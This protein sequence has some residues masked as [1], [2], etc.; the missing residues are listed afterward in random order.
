MKAAIAGATGFIGQLLIPFLSKDK[1]FESVDQC[2]AENLKR[3]IDE[4]YYRKE[5]NIDLITRF[6]FNGY[7]SLANN[8]LFPLSTYGLNTRKI[9]FLG[10]HI[11]AI[12][13]EEVLKILIK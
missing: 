11:R 9:A 13:T 7:M 12:A 2:V 10:Y 3:G 5:I 1:Q 4:G 6:Y 8:E